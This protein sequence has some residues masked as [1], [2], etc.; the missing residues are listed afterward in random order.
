MTD[1]TRTR[2][3]AGHTGDGADRTSGTRSGGGLRMHTLHADLPIPYLT[4]SD[5]TANARV[6]GSKLTP[7]KP[8]LPSMPSMPSLPP[9]KRLAF[10]GGL[11]ALAV[12]GALDWPVAVAIGA[13]TA[14]ARS[15]R[16]GEDGESD[17]GGRAKKGGRAE[18]AT[19]RTRKTA[20]TPPA[21]EESKPAA[22]GG[23]RGGTRGGARGGTRGAAKKATAKA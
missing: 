19:R 3:A 23:T 16:R 7:P 22:R 2:R 5:I 10:Y 18:S 17:G 6:A 8:P 9:P 1:A 13:A 12:L 21:E 11:G 20:A 14:V 4:A 15:G